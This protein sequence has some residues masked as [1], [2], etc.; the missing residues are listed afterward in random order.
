MKNNKETPQI[1]YIELGLVL[2][3]FKKKMN[4]KIYFEVANLDE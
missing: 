4:S 2:L 1:G 3:D